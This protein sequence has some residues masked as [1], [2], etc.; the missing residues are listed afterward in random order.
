MHVLDDHAGPTCVAFL[1]GSADVANHELFQKAM[2]DAERHPSRFIVLDI[3]ELTFLTSLAV[4]EI[5][6]LYK[7]KKKDGGNVLI[8]GAN[9]YIEG[10]FKAARLAGV[11]AMVP[12][13]EDA[14]AAC[15]KAS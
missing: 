2:A 13:V 1:K 3:R 8:A 9:Q 5:L 10:V 11:M 15:G 6:K 12:T 14:V 4:G 7:A